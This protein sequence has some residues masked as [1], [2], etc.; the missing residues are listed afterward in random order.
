MKV[1]N[2]NTQFKRE[3]HGVSTENL[4]KNEGKHNTRTKDKSRNIDAYEERVY[5]SVFDLLDRSVS[6]FWGDSHVKL[7]SENW[8]RR[9][10]KIVHAC[11]DDDEC[12]SD[13]MVIE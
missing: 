2:Q 10:M 9:E 13:C 1:E 11:R 4:I 5:V 7:V 12:R 3:L 8:Q 6:E